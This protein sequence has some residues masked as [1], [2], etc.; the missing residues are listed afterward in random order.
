LLK[1]SLIKTQEA[2]NWQSENLLVLPRDIETKTILWVNAQD[3]TEPELK[4]LQ[5]FWPC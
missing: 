1:I 5:T 2:V 3:P 4:E